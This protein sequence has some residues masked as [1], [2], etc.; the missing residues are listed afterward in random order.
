M[1]E[2]STSHSS[3]PFGAPV[4]GPTTGPVSGLPYGPA[5]GG[6]AY[7]PA[8]GGPAFGGP[9]RA[10]VARG[11]L[12]ARLG[13]EAL[14]LILAVVAVAVAAAAAGEFRF[15]AVA[16]PAAILGLYATAL[17]LSLRTATPNLAVTAIGALSGMVYAG[18]LNGD[19]I[20]SLPLAVALA[21]GVAAVVGVVLA[22]VVGLLSVPSWA[23]SLATIGGVQAILI[24]INEGQLERVVGDGILRSGWLAYVLCALVLLGSIGGGLLWAV[25]GVRRALSAN[26][27]VSDPAGFSGGRLVG[28]LV[29]LVGS[30]VL[31]GLAG[32]LF[33]ARTGAATGFV[34]YS[35]LILALGAALLGGVSTYGAR[36]GF[37]GTALAV[38][39]IVAI[40]NVMNLENAPRALHLGLAAL[41]A[42]V[43]FL[44]GRLLEYL[45]GPIGPPAAT[46][47]A[48]TP[49]PAA[50]TLVHAAPVP[51]ATM[52]PPSAPPAA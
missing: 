42:L 9:P 50:P 20:S 15:D 26:R 1:S 45:D 39:I 13:W 44:V 25:P 35:M 27:L 17:S 41:A 43:G 8:S 46:P 47:A 48:P 49:T 28:A 38:I 18:V 16:V 24:A 14:L 36:G 6:P 40:Q 31:G 10:T 7:S 2:P 37:A 22:L 19:E 4:S 12:F 32:V 5:S 34:D 30:S 51:F 33:A 11:G 21:V 3:L 29:G 52:P 23:A